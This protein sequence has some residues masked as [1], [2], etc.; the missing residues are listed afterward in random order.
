M[1]TSAIRVD[2]SALPQCKWA[3]A[4]PPGWFSL[5]MNDLDTFEVL[6]GLP[7]ADKHDEK[8]VNESA[9]RH[10]QNGF[11]DS[12]VLVVVYNHE[13]KATAAYHEGAKVA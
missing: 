13:G 7:T 9:V 5:T 1:T 3:K 10:S 4:K 6:D 2:L 11:G 12:K 8:S